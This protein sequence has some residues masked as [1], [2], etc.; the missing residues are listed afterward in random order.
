MIAHIC[1]YQNK[2]KVATEILV[3]YII[4]VC[5]YVTIFGYKAIIFTFVWFLKDFDILQFKPF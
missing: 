3:F 2:N 4:T 1:Q 5:K